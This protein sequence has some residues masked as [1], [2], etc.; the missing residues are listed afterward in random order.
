MSPNT[1]YLSLR[2]AQVQLLTLTGTGGTGKTRLALQAAAELLDD[3]ADGVVFVPLAALADPSL[4]PAAIATAVGVREEGGQPLLERL[5]AFLAR[6]S[7]CWSSTTG[8]TCLT[9]AADPGRLAAIGA[10]PDGAGH[11]PCAART[12]KPSASIRCRHWVCR[13][14]SPHPRWSSSPS[15]K[16][17]G[18]TSRGRKPVKPDFCHRQCQ[19]PGGGRD[20]SPARWLA[21][22]H[23]AGRGASAAPPTPGLAGP[24]GAAAAPAHGRGP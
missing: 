20:L 19:R 12:C 4:V 14:A 3:F 13:G 17:C 15:M 6:S 8:S 7:C 10:R 2:S 16:P 1:C 21:V 23:R 24:A 5:A 22:G 9:A 11:Q 18:S